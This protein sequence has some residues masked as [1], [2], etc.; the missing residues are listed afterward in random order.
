MRDSAMILQYAYCNAHPSSAIT[1]A[2]KFGHL[3]KTV[4]PSI[5]EIGTPSDRHI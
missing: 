4:M 3:D 1:P 2:L 5:L